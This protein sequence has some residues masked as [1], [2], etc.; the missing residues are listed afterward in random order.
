M[1]YRF[2]EFA[3]SNHRQYVLAVGVKDIEILLGLVDN[4]CN[5]MPRLAKDVNSEYND[6]Y[7]RIRNMRKT[8]QVALAE[9][10]RLDDHGER[11]K[12][13]RAVS[14]EVEGIVCGD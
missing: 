8:L 10:D 12:P 13:F 14:D 7:M 11:R 2:S 5:G 3:P 1:R 4:A 6:I 9:A